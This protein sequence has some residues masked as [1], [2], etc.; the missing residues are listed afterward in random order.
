MCVKSTVLSQILS[1]AIFFFYIYTAHSK[2]H[3]FEDE[4]SPHLNEISK[5]SR[6]MSSMD[7]QGRR[8]VSSRGNFAFFCFLLYGIAVF[9]QAKERKQQK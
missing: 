8:R 7:V 9:N 1:V 4:I 2:S 5:F 3:E 6:V